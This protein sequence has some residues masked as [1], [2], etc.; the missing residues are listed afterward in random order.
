MLI[1]VFEDR[2]VDQLFPITIGRVAYNITCGSYSLFDWLRELAAQFGGE[3]RSVVRPH[4]R[5]VQQT[6]HPT[7]YGPLPS[8]QPTLLVNAR[9]APSFATFETLRTL[10]KEASRG[11]VCSENGISYAYLPP[12]S[13]PPP[14]SSSAAAAGRRLRA[15][16]RRQTAS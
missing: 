16:Y 12:G 10:V 9:L 7:L 15:G 6:D 11:V 4:L 14:V 13:P 5:E 2:Q 3:L 8:G 1:I